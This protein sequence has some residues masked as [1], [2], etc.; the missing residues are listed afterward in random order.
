MRMLMRFLSAV[1]LAL[2]MILLVGDGIAMLAANGF[3]A[4]P[5]GTTIERFFPGTPTELDS[6]LGSVHPLLADPAL[7][8][9]LSWPGWAVFGAVGLGLAFLGRTPARRRLVSIDSY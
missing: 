3:V 1:F 8:T 4:T 6:L 5:L 9:L 7:T 2:A